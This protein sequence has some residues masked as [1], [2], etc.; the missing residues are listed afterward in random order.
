MVILTKGVD[1]IGVW[2]V[3]LYLVK[4]NSGAQ[5]SKLL[6]FSYLVLLLV[7]FTKAHLSISVGMI[8]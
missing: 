1:V 8:A 4:F 7:Y 6:K 2:H 3:D 5:V